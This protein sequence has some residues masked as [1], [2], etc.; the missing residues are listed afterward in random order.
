MP[1]RVIKQSVCTSPNFNLLD[2]AAEI[3]FYR[4]LTFADDHGCF[5]A[6]PD[7]LRG[8]LFPKK[9]SQWTY[10]K[11]VNSLVNLANHEIILLWTENNRLYGNFLTFASHQRVRSLHN[12]KTPKP[13]RAT[14]AVSVNEYLASFA[15]NCQ[16]V[17]DNCRQLTSSD[18]LKPKPKPNLKPNLNLKEIGLGKKLKPKTYADSNKKSEIQNDQAGQVLKLAFLKKFK[19][20]P[21]PYIG[22]DEDRNKAFSELD[23]I[24]DN[25]LNRVKGNID[26]F[27]ADMDAVASNGKADIGSLLYFLKSSHGA[28]RWDKLASEFTFEQ[29]AQLKKEWA[30]E[31]QGNSI[32]QTLA[33]QLT[34]KAGFPW[35][36]KAINEFKRLYA[37]WQSETNETE[38]YL[39]RQQIT[40]MQKKFGFL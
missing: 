33:E 40:T 17:A 9:M 13:K 39:L 36:E 35:Q 8:Q 15:V 2:D 31:L 18:R 12:R 38:K 37:R 3:L 27:L 1:N 10:K 11:I 34:S 32:A 5:E 24:L 22:K 30:E 16:Q 23:S 26:I 21:F 20:N 6:S 14:D 19:T 4:L 25:L 28:S 29:H 7:I